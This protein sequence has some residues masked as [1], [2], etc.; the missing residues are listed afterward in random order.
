MLKF[1]LCQIARERPS[2]NVY[3][4]FVAT[5]FCCPEKGPSTRLD[6]VVMNARQKE[7]GLYEKAGR[8]LTGFMPLRV[9]LVPA[10]L[11][12]A[13][14]CCISVGVRLLSARATSWAVVLPSGLRMDPAALETAV[15]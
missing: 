2:K 10:S 5:L 15:K 4:C 1:V 6:Q 13:C 7:C 12:P 11:M 8:G 14:S 9:R 3:S